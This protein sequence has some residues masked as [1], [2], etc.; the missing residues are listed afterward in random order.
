MNPSPRCG[1]A[2]KKSQTQVRRAAAR[3]PP[4]IPSGGNPARQQACRAGPVI[5]P[6]KPSP[7]TPSQAGT[8]L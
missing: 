2:T 5:G 6:P 8:R 4:P 3:D 1:N 7:R